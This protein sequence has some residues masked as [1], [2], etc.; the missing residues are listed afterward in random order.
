MNYLSKNIK[1]LYNN[2][3]NLLLVKELNPF[4]FY[5]YS[6]LI[7]MGEGDS[8]TYEKLMEKAQISKTTLYKAINGLK[9]LGLIYIQRVDD[10][11]FIWHVEQE[12]N[13]VEEE[14]FVEGKERIMREI[15]KIEGELSYTEDDDKRYELIEKITKL[16]VRLKEVRK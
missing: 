10:N 9:E 14:E 2:Q 15:R 5:I 16:H 8:P 6:L 3:L 13:I 1:N 11:T 4:E 7:S 12:I